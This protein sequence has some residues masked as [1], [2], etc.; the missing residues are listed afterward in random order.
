MNQSEK[1]VLKQKHS[2]NISAFNAQLSRKA[3][4]MAALLQE[5]LGRHDAMMVETLHHHIEQLD[6]DLKALSKVKGV[7]YKGRTATN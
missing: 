5:A 7:V 2:F 3:Y 6:G 4:V 1:R